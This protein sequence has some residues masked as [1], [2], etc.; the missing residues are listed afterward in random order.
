MN[1]EF[2]VFGKIPY[3]L[4]RAMYRVGRCVSSSVVAFF[5]VGCVMVLV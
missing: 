1:C 4:I 5:T 3:S 2:V